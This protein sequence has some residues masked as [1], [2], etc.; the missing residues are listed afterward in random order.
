MSVIQCVVMGCQNRS[1]DGGFVG[2]LCV[3]CHAMLVSGEV[4]RGATFVHDLAGSR[5]RLREANRLIEETGRLVARVFAAL[6]RAATAIAEAR[7]VI[8]TGEGTKPAVCS[9][10]GRDIGLRVPAD[11]TDVTCFDCDNNSGAIWRKP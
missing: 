8:G 1:D 5:D 11:A 10:C 7:T 4:G 2:Q 9:K 6:E 3:P